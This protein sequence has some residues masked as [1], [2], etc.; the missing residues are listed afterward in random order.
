MAL[1]QQY[2]LMETTGV[3]NYLLN[4]HGA[5]EKYL[6]SSNGS[7]PAGGG[8]YVLFPNGNMFAFA[9]DSNNDLLSTEAGTAISAGTPASPDPPHS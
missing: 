1:E 2:D 4:S 9:P 5:Q 3:T 8:Y 6:V 7:N